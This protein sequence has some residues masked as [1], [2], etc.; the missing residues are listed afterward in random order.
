MS[1]EWHVEERKEHEGEKKRDGE[2]E[3]RGHIQYLT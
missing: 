3:H 1:E 2:A